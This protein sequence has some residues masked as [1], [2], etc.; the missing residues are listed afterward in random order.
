MQACG[1]ILDNNVLERTHGSIREREK[2]MRGL[3]SMETPFIDGNK[4]YHNFVR[5]HE[6]L[7]GLIPAEAA[8]VGVGGENKWIEMLKRS[9]I[10]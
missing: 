1:L 9:V 5:P 4:I 8:G 6:A 10:K 7:N 3:K 2:I